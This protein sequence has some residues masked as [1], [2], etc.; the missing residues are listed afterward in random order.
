MMT[1]LNDEEL[2]AVLKD[3]VPEPPDQHHPRGE[4]ARAEARRIRVRRRAT[5]LAS[6]AA[7]AVLAAVPIVVLDDDPSET[8]PAVSAPTPC[9]GTE[10]DTAA[11]ADAIRK[12]LDLP[13]LA[14][15]ESCPVG[16][17]TTFPAGAGFSSRFTAIGPGPLYLTGTGV[18][19]ARGQQSQKVI[20][21]VD[22]DYGGPLLLR[23]D[24]IDGDGRLDFIHYLGAAG[25][26]GGA[27]DDSPHASLLY[28]RSAT[29]EAPA[30]I[31]QDYPSGV[32]VDEPGCYAIQV[33]GEGFSETLVFRV[34]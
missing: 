8:G 20:W 18:L 27:G 26:T 9:V 14:A 10:C 17:Q 33:D 16:G 5:V 2:A 19:R 31:L 13:T 12:P 4:L 24:R 15:G 1:Q 22:A 21:V 11:I 32:F 25:Y 23:G 29:G 28:P 34:E 3:T 7:V 6:A 30:R